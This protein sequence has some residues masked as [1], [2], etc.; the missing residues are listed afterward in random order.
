MIMIEDMARQSE[1]PHICLLWGEDANLYTWGADERCIACSRNTLPARVIRVDHATKRAIVAARD[2]IDEVDI[3]RVRTVLPGD[4][5]L[6]HEKVAIS[7][8]DEV[9]AY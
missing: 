4:L 6:V 9:D 8:L 3:S 2:Q 5:L 1:V 7:C